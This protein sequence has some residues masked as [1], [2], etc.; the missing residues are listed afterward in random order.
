[1]GKKISSEPIKISCYKAGEWTVE[2]K[3]LQQVFNAFND[4]VKYAEAIREQ[5]NS[6]GD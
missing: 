2:Y 6:D 1:M 4:A 5:E 3:E